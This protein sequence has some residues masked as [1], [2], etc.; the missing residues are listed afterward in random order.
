MTAA[1]DV[2]PP[3]GGEPFRRTVRT[4]TEQHDDGTLTLAARVDDWF[5]GFEVRLRC[6]GAEVIEASAT[7]HRHPWSS[8]PGALA[9]VTRLRGP[10]SAVAAQLAHAPRSTSCVH[11]TDLVWLAAQGHPLRVYTV[12]L[13][14]YEATLT[15]DGAEVLRWPLDE[16]K[17][18]DGGPFHGLGPGLKGWSKQLV[19]VRAD[20]EFREAVRVM[21]RGMLVGVG[22]YTLEWSSYACGADVPHETMTD[23]CYA[24]TADRMASSERVA[25]V[26]IP[27]I[28]RTAEQRRR[29]EAD[30]GSEVG[31]DPPT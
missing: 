16:F 28:R 26:P 25:R 10:L 7:A 15:R 19:S 3:S 21:R 17:I 5:H 12:E 11:V 18:A 13:D 14:P 24:F 8:C 9:S 1:P 29:F 23:S 6:D 4:S 30:A 22:Y 20:R 31:A 2:V 27:R